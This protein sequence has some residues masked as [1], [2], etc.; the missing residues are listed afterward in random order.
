MRTRRVKGIVKPDVAP[1]ASHLENV[2]EPQLDA[3]S[4][5]LRR[6]KFA[7]ACCSGEVCVCALVQP[8]KGTA[9]GR[10]CPQ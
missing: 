3:V 5:S 6:G 2:T 8:S 9:D 7:T 4:S 10:T 1:A